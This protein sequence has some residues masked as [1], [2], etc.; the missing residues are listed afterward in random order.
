[1]ASRTLKYIREVKRS[2]GKKDSLEENYKRIVTERLGPKRRAS[3][4]VRGTYN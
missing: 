1:M 2:L 3:M 4:L